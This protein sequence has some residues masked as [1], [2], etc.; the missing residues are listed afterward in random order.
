MQYIKMAFFKKFSVLSLLVSSL[1][2]GQ[3]PPP[4]IDGAAALEKVTQLLR[5]SPRD[6]GTENARKAAEW[7]AAQCRDTGAITT[8][9]TWK[10]TTDTGEVTFRN[11]I[12]VVPGA[13]RQR[14]IVGSHYDTKKLPNVPDF[15]GANDSGSS[16]GLLLEMIRTIQTAG[17]RPPFTL[18]CVFFD[19]EECVNT[20][21]ERDGLHGSRRH[22]AG[23][24][25]ANRVKD[26]RAMILLDMI[27]DKDLT[28]TLPSDTPPALLNRLL[29]AAAR[30][31][32][33]SKFTMSRHPIIDDHVPFAAIGIPAMDIIDFQYGPGNAYWHT[34]ADT[35]DKLSAKSLD[36]IGKVVLTMIWDMTE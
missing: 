14:I 25:Q 33:E 6:S 13:S 9:D 21:T 31:H 12:A 18:E 4:D 26:Y 28:V 36:I 2:F 11:V 5:F 23:I 35:L 16:T 10:E 34:A 3:P 24:K 30:H 1:L 17:T 27:G 8:M 22:A 32:V 19:G 20:Y 7:I 29:T 15:Q